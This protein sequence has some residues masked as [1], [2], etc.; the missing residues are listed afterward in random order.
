[1]EDKNNGD[2]PPGTIA[3]GPRGTDTAGADGDHPGTPGP[4]RPGGAVSARVSGHQHV[5]WDADRPSGL[6]RRAQVRGQQCLLV[7]GRHHDPGGLDHTR[8]V[9]WAT[10]TGAASVRM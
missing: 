1:M 4:G 10:D 5:H 8:P 7:V 3:G 2:E 9:A 6:P